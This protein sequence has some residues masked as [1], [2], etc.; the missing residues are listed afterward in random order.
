MK[1][2]S[3]YH[4]LKREAVFATLG[5]INVFQA[6]IFQDKPE[7]QAINRKWKWGDESFIIPFLSKPR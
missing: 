3:P 2:L 1:K 4:G 5:N 7:S 6:I